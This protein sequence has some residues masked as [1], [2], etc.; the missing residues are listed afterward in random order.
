MPF[1]VQQ[2]AQWDDKEILKFP[3]GLGAKKSIVIDAMDFNIPADGSRY[4]VP[5][6]TLL[7]ISATNV[8]KHVEYK[9]AGKIDGVL[10][11]PVDLLSR[12]TASSEPAPMFFFGC[13]FATQALVNFTLYLSAIM[14]GTDG[15]SLRAFNNFE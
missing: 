2:S 5:A 1:N 11:R 12:N 3:V 10:A 4:V 15:A 9:G 6:G 14:E 13:V 8:D 7:R